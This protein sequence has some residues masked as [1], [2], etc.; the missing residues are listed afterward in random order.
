MLVG[1]DVILL[2]V[3]HLHV[4]TCKF[5]TLKQ[6]WAVLKRIQSLMLMFCRNILLL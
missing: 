1:M 2:F 5:K 3:Q 6:Y 4:L